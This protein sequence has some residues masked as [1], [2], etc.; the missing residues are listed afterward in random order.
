MKIYEIDSNDLKD[1]K[2]RDAVIVKV[3]K[4]KDVLLMFDNLQNTIKTFKDKPNG[5]ELIKMQINVDT[6]CLKVVKMNREQ[7]KAVKEFENE[8]VKKGYTIQR[9]YMA[10]IDIEFILSIRK[11][12]YTYGITFTKEMNK[13]SIIEFKEALDEMK[14]QIEFFFKGDLND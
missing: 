14:P 7:E 9:N 8:L 4:V 2:C 3:V 1:C 11:E 13:L 12:R 5:Y 6:H 10:N